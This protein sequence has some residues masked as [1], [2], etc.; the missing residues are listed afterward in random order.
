MNVLLA[1]LEQ[2]REKLCGVR[3]QHDAGRAA[4]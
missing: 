1:V 3:Y 4:S 2:E